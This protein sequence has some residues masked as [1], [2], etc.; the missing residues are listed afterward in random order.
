MATD[1]MATLSKL[2]SSVEQHKAEAVALRRLLAA[3][4]ASLAARDRTAA[5]AAT[6]FAEAAAGKSHS[7]QLRSRLELEVKWLR[8]ATSK[9]EKEIAKLKAEATGAAADAGKAQLV[10]ARAPRGGRR[11]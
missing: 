2:Q 7:D 6:S 9:A 4:E 11:R 3:S 8:D 10:R 5:T 1:F